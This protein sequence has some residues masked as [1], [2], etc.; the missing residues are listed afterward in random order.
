MSDSLI[1]GLVASIFG[2]ALVAITN[3]IFTRN[4][5]NAEAKKLEA[6]AEKIKAETAKLL[7][8]MD[9]KKEST[10]NT[11]KLPTGWYSAGSDQYDY[12]MG[13]DHRV[14]HGGRFSG[15]IKSLPSPKG[16]GTLMQTI[17]AN[18]YEGKRLRLS[19]FVKAEKV[20]NYAGLWMRVDGKNDKSVS[21]D[22]MQDRPIKGTLDWKK[23]EIVL[24][25]PKDSVGI[26]FGV[27]L[28]GQGQV[29]IDDLN[30]EV[31]GEDVQTTDL[32]LK[33][34][35]LPDEPINLNFESE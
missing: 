35:Q 3:H 16:F 11:A 22:N 23:Y 26:A 24:D 1:I 13:V 28:R 29:W 20:R 10:A 32:K 25:V 30:L 33:E 15:Y 19:G 21:F 14:V 4:K 8:D 18:K 6:E 12:A 27:L 34:K 7:N 9:L 17:K 5:T 31:V 2:G